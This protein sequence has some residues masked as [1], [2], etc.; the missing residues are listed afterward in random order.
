MTV[1]DCHG[2][3]RYDTE[4]QAA[5]VAKQ[6]EAEFETVWIAVPHGTD[7]YHAIDIGRPT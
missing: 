3:A 2:H 5:Y 7:H 1:L 6:L 4:E